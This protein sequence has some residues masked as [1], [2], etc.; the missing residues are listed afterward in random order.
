MRRLPR[1]VLIEAARV[2]G[3]QGGKARLQRMTAEQR[4]A[5]ARK[6]AETR[7]ARK[8]AKKQQEGQSSATS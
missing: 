7:W 4:Q 1:A 5:V 6:A 3:R 2:F 8:R